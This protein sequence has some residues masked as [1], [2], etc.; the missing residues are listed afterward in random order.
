MAQR[1]PGLLAAALLGAVAILYVAV[2]LGQSEPNN[3]FRG[4]VPMYTGAML[5]AAALAVGGSLARDRYWR[6]LQ[7]GI[8]AGITLVCAW[9]GALSIGM[10]CAPAAFPS[11]LNGRPLLTI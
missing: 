2:I 3:D 11:R 7:F 10:L 5:L 4:V 9:L 6:R 8:A 1:L